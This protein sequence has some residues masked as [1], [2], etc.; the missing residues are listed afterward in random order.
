[1]TSPRETQRGVQAGPVRSLF[2]DL[3]R[4]EVSP[5]E[6]TG[7]VRLF[8]AYDRIPGAPLVDLIHFVA[9]PPGSTLG[10]HRHGDDTEWYVI[11]AGA[12]RM[13]VDGREIE[14]AAGDVVINRP[15]GEHGLVNDSNDVL[16]V[17]VWKVSPWATHLS[18]KPSDR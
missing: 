1:M 18:D 10:R 16:H 11:L 2:D 7:E 17:I 6:G 14:V 15:F 9:M 12:G 4:S 13:H 8:R 5:H 3:M